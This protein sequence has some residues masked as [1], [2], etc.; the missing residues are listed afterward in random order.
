MIELFILDGSTAPVGQIKPGLVLSAEEL[1]SFAGYRAES[2]R[3][4][5]LLGR[6]L[7]KMALTRRNG[8][9]SLD[10]P[11]ISTSL[12]ATGKPI[13]DG[14]QFSLSHDSGV[15]LL[16]I[17]DQPVGVD[18]ESVQHFD[19]AMIQ[20]CFNDNEQRQIAGDPQPDRA[21]TLL[22]CSKEAAAKATGRGLLSELGKTTSREFFQRG[23]FL[24]IGGRSR[25]YALCSPLP[26]APVSI[27]SSEDWF[28][29]WQTSLKPSCFCGFVYKAIR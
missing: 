16:A 26:I 9:C 27:T 3:R 17:G 6:L 23:G 18:I 1:H 24:D 13:V 11:F 8:G 5:F 20:M 19:E 10:F 25:A 28:E 2:R 14:A 4:D 29:E 7:L 12:T 15:I 22:W 21:A